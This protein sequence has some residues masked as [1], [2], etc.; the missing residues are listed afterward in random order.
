VTWEGCAVGESICRFIPVKRADEGIN[1]LNFVYE[2]DSSAIKR[3][4]LR[5]AYML[6]IVTSGSAVL[7]M[8]NEKYPLKKGDIFLAF[9][10]VPYE[11]TRDEDLSYMYITFIGMRVRSL[12]EE[13]GISRSR[14]VYSGLGHLLPFWENAL[15]MLVPANANILAESVLLFTLSHMCS[16]PREKNQPEES[17]SPAGDIKAFVDSHYTDPELSLKVLSQ[18]FS[19][20]E[21]YISAM[22]KKHVGTA[23][24]DYLRDLRIQRACQLMDEGVTVMS[25][26]AAMSGFK[27]PLYFSK[28]FKA[29]MDRSPSGHMKL[30]R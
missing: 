4:F 19:Y 5:S 28:V 16:S 17:F 24:S 23:F 22:F 26:V 21:K 7:E 11:I 30:R 14:P 20:S 8:G 27:D 18:K 2:A 1:T 13:L 25:E 15:A 6:H 3:P 29:K 10:A 12:F 9:A